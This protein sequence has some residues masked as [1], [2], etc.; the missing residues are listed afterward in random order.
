MYC[1]C[2]TL[3]IVHYNGSIKTDRNQ[4]SIVRLPLIY[5]GEAVGPIE[6]QPSIWLPC[7]H[8]ATESSKSQ[9]D[10]G[11]HAFIYTCMGTFW[12]SPFQYILFWI[13]NTGYVSP[14][15]KIDK[16]PQIS[17]PTKAIRLGICQ[18]IYRSKIINFLDFTWAKGANRDY[19]SIRIYWRKG[20]TWFTFAL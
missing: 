3:D 16:D 12:L 7:R 20:V 10:R 13:L 9:R 18:I 2:V 17:T 14:P 4:Q 1:V 15:H 19:W 11:R 8:V 6:A 5:S